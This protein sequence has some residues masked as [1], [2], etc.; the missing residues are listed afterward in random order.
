MQ[1]A[2]SRSTGQPKESAVGNLYQK[3][4]NKTKNNNKTKRRRE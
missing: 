1:S 2:A 4:K 3:K